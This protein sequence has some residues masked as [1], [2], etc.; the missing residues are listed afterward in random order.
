MYKYKAI[1]YVYK[2]TYTYIFKKKSCPQKICLK[3]EKNRKKQG[4]KQAS[5]SMSHDSLF[6]TFFVRLGSFLRIQG[7]R[8]YKKIWHPGYVL[9]YD[10][11]PILDELSNFTTPRFFFCENK[12]CEKKA[13]LTLL[14]IQVMSHFWTYVPFWEQQAPSYWTRRSGNTFEDFYPTLTH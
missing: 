8:N 7:W 1:H 2:F 10:I 6:Q 3:T 14:C 5:T 12:D 11:C 4:L 13:K 9:L